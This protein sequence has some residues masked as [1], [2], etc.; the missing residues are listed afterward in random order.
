[1]KITKKYLREA[2]EKEIRQIL[3][4]YPMGE[5]STEELSAGMTIEEKYEIA[6][7]GLRKIATSGY[8]PG[9]RREAQSAL[10]TLGF[11]E[12]GFMDVGDEMVGSPEYQRQTDSPVR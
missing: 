8:D 4:E 12:T 10:K 7:A 2:V 9:D 3:N 6:L 5:Y 11:G 1:V